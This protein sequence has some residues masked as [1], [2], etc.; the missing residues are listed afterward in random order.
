[1]I[2]KRIVWVALLVLGFAVSAQAQT[3]VLAYVN[4]YPD[5]GL[6]HVDL[7]VNNWQVYPAALFAPAP[8]L[9]PCGANPDSS[10]TWVEIYNRATNNAIY[11]FCA[12]R[13]PIQLTRLW[14]ATPPAKKPKLVYIIMID[15]LA[16]KKY[17]SNTVAIP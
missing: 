4:Q 15:R 14:F 3:P 2:V 17:I 12:L 5:M 13:E 10:R 11:G 9:P 6:I 8:N 16:K 7:R 1:M